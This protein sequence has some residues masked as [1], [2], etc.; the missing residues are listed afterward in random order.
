[1]NTLKQTT[2]ILFWTIWFHSYGLNILIL[3]FFAFVALSVIDTLYWYMLARAWMVVSSKAW[4]LWIE[5][6]VVQGLIIIIAILFLWAVSH[7]VWYESVKIACSIIAFLPIVG[8]GRWQLQ[9]II[10]NMAIGAKG[11]ELWFINLL[12]RLFGIGEKKLEEKI[13]KYEE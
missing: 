9:S 7:E 11:R 13:K 3:W 1:M 12:L 4:N 10:E 6:K 8:F 5:R 2:L